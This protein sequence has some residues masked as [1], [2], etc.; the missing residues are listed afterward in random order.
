MPIYSSSQHFENS[1]RPL[2]RPRYSAS[3]PVNPDSVNSPPPPNQAGQSVSPSAY[4]PASSEYINLGTLPESQYKLLTESWS[5]YLPEFGGGPVESPSRASNSLAKILN[6][7]VPS[8]PTSPHHLSSIGVHVREIEE[9]SDTES[10]LNVLNSPKRGSTK[11]TSPELLQLTSAAIEVNPWA[12]GYGEKTKAWKEVA[13]RVQSHNSAFRNLNRLADTYKRKMELLLVWHD[14]GPKGPNC[15]IEKDVERG[16][17]VRITI[18]ALLDKACNMRDEAAGMSEEK[19]KKAKEIQNENKVGGESIRRNAMNTM[20][21][22]RASQDES[23]KENRPLEGHS[24]AKRPRRSGTP[25]AS[26]LD[27]KTLMVEDIE[28]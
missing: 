18:S 4:S 26:Q 24:Q 10:T 2:T 19:K 27:V 9:P 12:A 25:N 1:S 13:D 16:R 5:D 23:D 7:P 6:S 14:D 8:L 21:K 20:K 3:P 22:H 11:F 28:E 15:S 17:D